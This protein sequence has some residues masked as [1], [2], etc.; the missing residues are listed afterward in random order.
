MTDWDARAMGS[1]VEG[2]PRRTL[3]QALRYHGAVHFLTCF[4]AGRILEVG[5]GASGLAAFWPG[6]VSGVDVRFDGAPLP[7]L[8][9][10]QG[11]ATALPFDDGAFDAVVCVD[12]FEHMPPDARFAAFQEM[13]R[14]SDRLVWLAF[15]SGESAE[16]TD[17]RI[18]VLARRLGRPIPGWLR[19]HLGG[20]FPAQEES[21][22][23][24][25]PGF[26]RGHRRSLSCAAHI[27]V[28]LGEHAPGG[29]ALDALG[30]AAAARKA[31][32]AT[33]GPRYRLEQWFIRTS[34]A[35]GATA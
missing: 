28:I 15:P 32:L 29:T 6:V 23:W 24:P 17:R 20:G 26:A 7:N 8:T 12:V 14:V 19:D 4:G 21:L 16:R 2:R 5:S 25:C 11:S 18:A 30:G 10:I 3:D 13:L 33:P 31:I 1:S 35:T 34:P 22:D 9:T 27:G